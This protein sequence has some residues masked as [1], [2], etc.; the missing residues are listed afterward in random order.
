MSIDFKKVAIYDMPVYNFQIEDSVIEYIAELLELIYM[1]DP[2]Q[3]Q[4][5]NMMW[6]EIKNV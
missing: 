4:D 1:S 6:D 3:R 5:I 2:E